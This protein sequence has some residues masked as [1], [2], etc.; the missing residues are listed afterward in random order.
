MGLL[1][2]LAGAFGVREHLDRFARGEA[3]FD[4]PESTD[5]KGFEQMVGR[6][7]RED[8]EEAFGQ[9]ARQVD[10][11]EYD[12]HI[13]PGVRGTD[14]LG[15]LGSGAL[16]ALAGALLGNL[17]GRGSEGGDLTSLVPGLST[18]DPQRMSRQDVASLAS[19][20]RQRDPEAFGRAAAQVGREEP[21]LVTRLLGNKALMAAA[22]GLAAKYMNDRMRRGD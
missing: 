1:D 13:T 20:A 8:L 10:A 11:R 16:G 12:D 9:A 18:T 14:P 17:T 6:A 7:P 21:S 2:Q 5:T 19:Y 15:G 4:D 22:A 3:N